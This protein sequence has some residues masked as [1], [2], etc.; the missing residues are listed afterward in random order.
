MQSRPRNDEGEK[1]GLGCCPATGLIDSRYIRPFSIVIVW[2]HR[3]SSVSGFS[4]FL[5]PIVPLS[6]VLSCCILI[7]QL[8]YFTLLSDQPDLPIDRDTMHC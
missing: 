3:G 4:L 8:V 7:C 1:R 5:H 6:S 2:S